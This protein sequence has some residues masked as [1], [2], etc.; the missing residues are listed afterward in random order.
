MSPLDK[1]FTLLSE[2]PVDTRRVL[3]S[4]IQALSGILKG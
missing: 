2:D 3:F 1:V 4:A